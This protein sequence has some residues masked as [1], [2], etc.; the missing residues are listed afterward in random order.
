MPFL[1]G[2]AK[3]FSAEIL[4]TRELRR[5][6]LEELMYPTCSQSLDSSPKAAG[7][8][9]ALLTREN[10]PDVDRNTLQLVARL[11]SDEG[12]GEAWMGRYL[13]AGRTCSS[14]AFSKLL[15]R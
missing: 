11:R 13:E 4:D 10:P 5:Q 7:V 1:T 2:R 14:T 8:A 15:Q 3:P 9:Y 6:I 12:A